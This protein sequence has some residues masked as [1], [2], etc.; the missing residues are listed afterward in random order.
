MGIPK[1]NRYLSDNCKKGTIKKVHLSELSGKI[2]VIDVSIYLYKFLNQ[3]DLIENMYLFISILKQYNIIPIFIFDGKPP[4]EKKNILIKRNKEKKEA[5][6][7]Y[8]QLESNII[9]GEYTKEEI[10]EINKKI[11]LLKKKSIKI[12]NSEIIKVKELMTLYGVQYYDAIQ[13]ADQ[14]CGVISK[15][16]N[17]FGCISDD[18]DMFM[19]ECKY[20]IR[21]ISL[22][23]HTAILYNCKDIYNDLNV[24]YDDLLQILL[25]SGS[26][27]N[28][29]NKISIDK[30]F[31][32][33]YKYKENSTNNSL[34]EYFNDKEDI[35]IDIVLID[36]IKKII[37][38]DTEYSEFTF[39]L[40]NNIKNNNGLR[41]YLKE[42]GFYWV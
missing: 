27:Y 32:I 3:G 39:N 22:I 41:E 6:L 31:E 42:Y 21:H 12:K 33:F 29:N 30:A 11:E 1:L 35:I 19:Y 7:E 26:D 10:I 5:E 13:E 18:M 25:I 15:N 4:P 40:H 16:N 38:C 24:N 20:I 28:P 36:N 37:L 14:L 9:T 8:K 2:L 17:V 34:Y 23:N